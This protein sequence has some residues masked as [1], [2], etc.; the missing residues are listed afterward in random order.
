V[1][2]LTLVQDCLRQGRVDVRPRFEEAVELLIASPGEQRRLEMFNGLCEIA[3]RVSSADATSGADLL[4]VLV[5][6]PNRLAEQAEGEGENASLPLAQALLGEA[7]DCLEDP[8]G[9]ALMVAAAAD[10]A[11]SPVADSVRGFVAPARLGA[12]PEE[13]VALA[14]AIERADA[15]LET[16][17]QLLGDERLP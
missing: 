5:P 1:A 10:L 11:D 3:L 8:R 13:A 6:L 7:L 4:E 9:Q 17:L 14:A 12:A 16:R 15:R 2:V